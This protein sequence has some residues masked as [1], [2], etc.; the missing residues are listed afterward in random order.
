M[1]INVVCI[2]V[3]S[4]FLKDHLSH[5]YRSKKKAFLFLKIYCGNRGTMPN[6]QGLV[7]KMVPKNTSLKNFIN[8]EARTIFQQI[9][10]I[11]HA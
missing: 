5:K 11:S 7:V 9:R 8:G 3:F 4:I 1:L 6:R 2:V 10:N